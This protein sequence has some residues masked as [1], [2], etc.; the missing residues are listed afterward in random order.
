MHHPFGKLLYEWQ[1]A[2]F[3]AHFNLMMCVESNV[4]PAAVLLSQA[5]GDGKSLVRDSYATGQS[6]LHW[7]I[8]P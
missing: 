5:T 6:G 7:S 2:I 1:E 3:L 8:S 4:P